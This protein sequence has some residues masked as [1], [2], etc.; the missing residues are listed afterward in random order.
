MSLLSELKKL[1]FKN[2]GFIVEHQTAKHKVAGKIVKFDQYELKQILPSAVDH[3]TITI[4]EG[5]TH[6]SFGAFKQISRSITKIVL[7]S[8]LVSVE[9]RGYVYPFASCVELESI[10]VNNPDQKA[11]PFFCNKNGLYHNDS[12]TSLLST[13][14]P[15]YLEKPFDVELVYVPRS[16]ANGQITPLVNNNPLVSFDA[17]QTITINNGAFANAPEVTVCAT[18][19]GDQVIELNNKRDESLKHNYANIYEVNGQ[20]INQYWDFIKHGRMLT[21]ISTNASGTA[22]VSHIDYYDEVDRFIN[23][24]TTESFTDWQRKHQS[25]TKK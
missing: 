25:K 3:G 1:S 12:C 24:A 4:P 20:R 14:D 18:L 10:S 8:T 16:K 6:I 15:A 9:K 11:T 22:E 17:V 19:K 23:A 7:P 2:K 13:F 21:Q 5:I